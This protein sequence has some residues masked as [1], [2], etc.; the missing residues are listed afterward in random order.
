MRIEITDMPSG[1]KTVVDS[2]LE[3]GEQ[4]TSRGMRHLEVIGASIVIHNPHCSYA[5]KTGRE[6]VPAI[7]WVEALQLVAGEAYP[8][9]MV[10]VSGEFARYRD[11]EV[12]HGAYGPR[13]RPQM[14]SVIHR[15]A[16]PD[17]RQ[18]VVTIW[19]PMYDGQNRKDL[20][21]TLSFQFLRR[22]DELHMVTTMRSNDVWLGFPY[23]VF[24]FTFLQKT[25][26]HVLGIQVGSYVHNVGSLHIY[27]SD[28]P[29]VNK[30]TSRLA[31]PDDYMMGVTCKVPT[32]PAVARWV[33]VQHRANITLMGQAPSDDWTLYQAVDAINRRVVR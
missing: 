23:D 16:A 14:E 6:L 29:K 22:G 33:D 9:L 7:A 25:L 10:A 17:S 27:E 1:Y 18:A 32:Y 30:L 28:L 3:R 24:Q 15:L 31:E 20:P 2:V 13:I 26:A 19:D 5:R 21:C 4:A 8:D 11:G 12:F